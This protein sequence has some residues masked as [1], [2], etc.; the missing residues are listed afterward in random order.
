MSILEGQQYARLAGLVRVRRH[1]R[2]G[3]NTGAVDAILPMAG[4]SALSITVRQTEIC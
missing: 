3:N 1:Q 4:Q 2:V